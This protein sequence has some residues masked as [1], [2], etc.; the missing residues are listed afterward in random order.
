M[1]LTGNANTKLSSMISVNE[2]RQRMI[3]E[4]TLTGMAPRSQQTYLNAVDRLAARSWKSIE[5]MTERDVQG[6]LL[7]LRNN[8]AA[9]GTFKTAWFG[10]Q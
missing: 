6:Y 10:V 5:D 4:L 2:L 3:D 1:N 8:G 9:R 7:N